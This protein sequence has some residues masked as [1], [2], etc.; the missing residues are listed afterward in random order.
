MFK[1]DIGSIYIILK[2]RGSITVRVNDVFATM[3]FAFDTNILYCQTGAFYWESQT[4]YTGFNLMF[5]GDKNS[6]LQRK[7]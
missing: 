2:G 1:M 4:F 7:H 3:N 6:A 5:G